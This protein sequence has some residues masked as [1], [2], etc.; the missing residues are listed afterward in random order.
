MDYDFTAEIMQMLQALGD[1]EYQKTS[2]FNKGPYVSSPGEMLCSYFDDYDVPGWIRERAAKLSAQQGADL[3]ALDNAMK[4]F[5]ASTDEFPD[6]TLVI[7]DPRWLRI[8]ELAQK[9][10]ASLAPGQ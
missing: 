10:H 1:S 8:R 2:W 6:P 4:E 5:S 3:V 7:V 9:A